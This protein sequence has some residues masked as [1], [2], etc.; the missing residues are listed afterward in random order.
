MRLPTGAKNPLTI[1]ANARRIMRLIR[2]EKVDIVHARS[3]APAWSARIACRQAGIPFVTTFHGIYGEKNS[4]KRLYNSVMARGDAIIANSHYTAQI[5]KERYGAEAQRIIVIPRGV[6]S[7][8]FD[9]TAVND[10]RR[11]ALRREWGIHPGDKIVLQLARLAAWKG[12]RVLI[13]AAA[14]PPLAGRSDIAFVLAGDDQGRIEYRRDLEERIRAAGLDGRVRLVGHCD[15]VP[16]ALALAD[17]AVIAST[18]PEGFGRSAIEAAA[19]GVPVVAASLGATPE[20]VLAPP[21]MSAAERTGWLVP[22]ND[23]GVLASA[24]GGALALPAEE[25]QALAARARR[26]AEAFTAEAMQEATLRIYER[27]VS[28]RRDAKAGS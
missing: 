1:L 22:P 11:A 27:L 4:A 24:I 26:H 5:I 13:E 18:E 23:A 6:D 19:M 16:A 21:A 15:D 7:V 25:R 17:L 2:A 28:Q 3:R 8:R 9:P 14:L 12:Q 20:T 10:E